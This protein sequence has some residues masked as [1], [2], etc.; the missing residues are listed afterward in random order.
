MPTITLKNTTGVNQALPDLG[1]FVPA[2]GQLTVSDSVNLRDVAAS[3]SVRTLVLA[4]TLVVNDGS[5]DLSTEN[6]L[7]YLA[8]I[9]SYVGFDNVPSGLMAYPFAAG[10]ARRFWSIQQN[11]GLTSTNNSGFLTAPTVNGT[12][13]VT[14]DTDGQWLNY[15]TASII[16]R[17]GGWISSNFN[18]VQRQNGPIFGIVLKTG[19]VLADIQNARIWA[20]LFSATPMAAA[21]PA[22]HLAGF[23]YD[24]TVDGTAFWRCVTNNGGAGT[25]TTTLVA[26]APNT[27]YE[28]M[29]DM[30]DQSNVKFYIN[31]AL[32]AT[33][34]ATLPGAT[35]NLGHQEQL[36]TLAAAAKNVK[37]SRVFM[38]HN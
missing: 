32:V 21:M 24:T 37:L 31:G 29:V 19:S 7:S 23:R 13:S 15:A 22:I 8:T 20:G 25:I 17:D 1:T 3:L 16:D 26:V 30:A 14:H 12:S 9:W 36:R 4:G 2:S 5:A 10:R 27:K 33:H 38:E 34:T 35:Q 6:G 11:S 28:L 18:Q